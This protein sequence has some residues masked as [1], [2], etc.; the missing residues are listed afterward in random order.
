MG[1]PLTKKDRDFLLSMGICPN[2]QKRAIEPNKHACY[3]CLGRERDRYHRRKAD[4][5][6]DKKCAQDNSR[7]MTVYYRR[8]RDG[9]CTRCGKRNAQCGLLCGRCYSKYRSK[10]LLKQ[11]D[12]QRSERPAYGRCYICG[13]DELYEG[14]K[15]CKSCYETRMKTIPAMLEN[16]NN[17]HY[18]SRNDLDFMLMKMRM[19]RR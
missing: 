10:Q 1:K 18:R 12:I 14:H 6:L 19:R 13:A 15:V 2:C 5:S 4:G 11:D 16:K 3:E 17:A 7:K 9:I 8:K